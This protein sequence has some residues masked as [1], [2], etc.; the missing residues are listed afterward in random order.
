[1]ILFQFIKSGLS[2]QKDCSYLSEEEI[3][4]VK[5]EMSDGRIDVKKFT[6]NDQLHIYRVTSL[7]EYYHPREQIVYMSVLFILCLSYITIRRLNLLPAQHLHRQ[8]E[9][10]MTWFQDDNQHILESKSNMHRLLYCPLCQKLTSKTKCQKLR[11]DKDGK[12]YKVKTYHY[13]K[14]SKL[15]R[16]KRKEQK[17]SKRQQEISNI[18]LSKIVNHMF[19]S[20]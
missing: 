6:Q 15:K 9:K 2:D 7:T 11:Q 18:E 17:E 4:S 12:L 13:D 16:T 5:R 20:S 19:N 10:E 1:M 3:T 8:R 14:L